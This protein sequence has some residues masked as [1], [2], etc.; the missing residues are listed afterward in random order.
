MA[1]LGHRLWQDKDALRRS[2][3][4]KR[5]LGGLLLLL[6]VLHGLTVTSWAVNLRHAAP[7][8]VRENNNGSLTQLSVAGL[9]LARSLLESLYA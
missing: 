5:P 2:I 1:G 8:V 6:D 9:P 4:S 3:S 7:M